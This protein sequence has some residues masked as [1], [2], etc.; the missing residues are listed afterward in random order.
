MIHD[1]CVQYLLFKMASNFRFVI[2]AQV[3]H[4]K[5]VSVSYFRYFFLVPRVWFYQIQV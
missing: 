5:L 1:S 3:Q 2:T 4:D